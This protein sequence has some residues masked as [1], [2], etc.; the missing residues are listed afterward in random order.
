MQPGWSSD[1]TSR[2]GTFGRRITGRHRLIR[3]HS[4]SPACVEHLND[5][6]RRVFASGP[7]R[8]CGASRFNKSQTTQ[9]R[10][11]DLRS[12]SRSRRHSPGDLYKDLAQRRD[13]R[14]AP[15]LSD[16]LDVHDPAQHR[17]RCRA[18]EEAAPRRHRGGSL[19][20]RL[21][22]RGDD[23]N[24]DYQFRQDRSYSKRSAGYPKIVV[25]S[26]N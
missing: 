16:H 11:R 1:L 2:H 17:A 13:L 14:S 7:T 12:L 25:S 26:L 9:D 24:F 10:Y 23:D 21:P 5:L 18:P 4:S 8:L 15:R 19:R 22:G 6:L 20:S 3:P